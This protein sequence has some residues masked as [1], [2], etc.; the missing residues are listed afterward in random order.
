MIRYLGRKQSSRNEDWLYAIQHIEDLITEDEV[1]EYAESTVAEILAVTAGK[2]TAYGWSGGKDSIVL[3][4]LCEKAG[5]K[6]GFFA[7]SDLDYPEFVEWCIKNKPAG[8][9]AVNTGYDLNWLSHHQELLFA[10]GTT[11]QRWH[12]INQRGPFT[13]MF[14]ENKL[15]LLIVGHRIIDGNVCGENGFVRKKSGEI[16]YAPMRSWPHEALLGYIHYQHL[17]LPPIYEWKDGF[18]QGTHAWPEREFCKTVMQGYQEVYDIDPSIVI[19]ASEKL[20]SARHF[21]EEV[22]E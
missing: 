7:Y 14:F 20:S 17:D 18:V 1:R 15:D 13:R 19:A 5:I 16:R 22:A 2:K 4:S 10:E 3:A 6:T 21:L 12:Q 11:G 8:V 9:N